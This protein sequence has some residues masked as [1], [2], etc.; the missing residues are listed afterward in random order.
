MRWLVVLAGC[1]AQPPHAPPSAPAPVAIAEPAAPY[2]LRPAVRWLI[3]G[4]VTVN[5][6][7][8]E[9]VVPYYPGLTV[10]G[11]LR[12]GGAARAMKAHGTLTRNEREEVVDYGL[13]V[14]KILRY[15][16]PD[17]ELAPGDTLVI[18][19]ESPWGCR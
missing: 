12:I 18:E 4:P 16:A 11:A 1:A 5:L 19:C 8:S 14:G 17:P 2:P 7:G 6:M 9:V 10:R 15:E 3:A 13:P